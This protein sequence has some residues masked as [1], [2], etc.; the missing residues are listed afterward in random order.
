AALARYFSEC[1]PL[2]PGRYLAAREPSQDN[3]ATCGTGSFRRDTTMPEG[4]PNR[5]AQ[6]P[7]A[8]RPQ[9]DRIDRDTLR[10]AGED[11]LERVVVPSL[12]AFSHS[13]AAGGVRAQVTVR[14]AGRQPPRATLLVAPEGSPLD[15]WAAD[16]LTFQPGGPCGKVLVCARTGTTGR[17]G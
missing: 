6:W 16:A 11:F 8:Q 1:P 15:T 3:Q 17:S 7:K 4:M 10:R 13:L 9:Q 12:R 2:L 5:D 14:E